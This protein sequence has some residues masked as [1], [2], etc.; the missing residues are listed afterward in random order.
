MLWGEEIRR[1]MSCSHCVHAVKTAV[2]AVS[3]M[4]QMEVS[5][6]KNLATADFDPGVAN[7]RTFRGYSN[8][9]TGL[10]R[11]AAGQPA[12]PKSGFLL[13]SLRDPHETLENLRSAARVL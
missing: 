11:P 8:G 4:E 2:K 12:D 10:T 5:L 1:E 6:E 3:G 13:S 9:S 7:R